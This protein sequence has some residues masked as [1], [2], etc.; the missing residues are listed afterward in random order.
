MPL[1][2][3]SNRAG[4]KQ[5]VTLP[6]PNHQFLG[7]EFIQLVQI[8]ARQILLLYSALGGSCLTQP[9]DRLSFSSLRLFT[10]IVSF[11]HDSEI[12][13]Y[14]RRSLGSIRE[15][16]DFPGG[17]LFRISSKCCFQLMNV[18]SVLFRTTSFSFL[19]SSPCICIL[20]WTPS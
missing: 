5:F 9:P 14:Q 18:L 19:T 7:H 17:I 15:G 10:T 20:L 2:P 3:L 12:Q 11:H 16:Y 8:S 4:H 6:E 1:Y 13:Q